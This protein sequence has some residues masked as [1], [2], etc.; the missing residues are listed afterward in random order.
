MSFIIRFTFIVSIIPIIIFMILII[1][2]KK[3]TDILLIKLLDIIL[4]KN[5]PTS[6]QD[7]LSTSLI[8]TLYWVTGE[9]PSSEGALKNG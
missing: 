9:P 1:L 8:S 2:I 7:R 4:I 3:L 5:R 6:F